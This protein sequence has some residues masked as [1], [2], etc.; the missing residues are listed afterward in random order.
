MKQI[1]SAR[2][3]SQGYAD[4]ADLG[5]F[6][7]LWHQREEA[8]ASEENHL[9]CSKNCHVLAF[10]PPG[11]EGKENSSCWLFFPASE[12]EEHRDRNVMIQTGTHLCESVLLAH[13]GI[14]ATC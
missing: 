8:A 3:R 9:C 4:W 7:D 6:S 10:F 1:H 2:H 12:G 11:W 14:R 13:Q 5:S